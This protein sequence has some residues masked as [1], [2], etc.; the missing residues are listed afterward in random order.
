MPAKP[1]HF[2]RMVQRAGSSFPANKMEGPS[3]TL[4]FLGIILDTQRMEIRLPQEKLTQIQVKLETWLKKRK[5]TKEKFFH[6]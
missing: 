3:T 4:T 1:E 2:H 5:A 6:W